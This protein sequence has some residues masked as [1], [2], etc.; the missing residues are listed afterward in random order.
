MFEIVSLLYAYNKIVSPP[1]KKRRI[2][3]LTEFVNGRMQRH[4]DY[5]EGPEDRK[6]VV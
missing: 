6:S 5:F 1:V 2:K 3:Q 4:I